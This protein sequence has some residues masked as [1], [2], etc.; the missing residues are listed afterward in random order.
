MP[1]GH[2]LVV[3]DDPIIALDIESAVLEVGAIDATVC[4]SLAEARRALSGTFDFALLDIDLGDGL[5]Y[6]VARIL[7]DRGTPFVFVTATRSA[8]V[9]SDLAGAP[10]IAKPFYRNAISRAVTEGLSRPPPR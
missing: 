8:D 1:N 10:L 2:V 9:P 4:A 6:E 3:E 5:S 7:R